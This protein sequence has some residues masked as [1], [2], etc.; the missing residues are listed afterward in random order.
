MIS[1]LDQLLARERR[2]RLIANL[3]LQQ[4]TCELAMATRSRSTI[5]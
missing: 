4:E 3:K 5:G 1:D 2:A